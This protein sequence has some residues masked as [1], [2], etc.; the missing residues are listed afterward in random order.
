M[1]A[2]RI[3]SG[4]DDSIVQFFQIPGKVCASGRGKN[5]RSRWK[6]NRLQFKVGE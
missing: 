2:P 3:T 1:A 4:D 6:A 5:H